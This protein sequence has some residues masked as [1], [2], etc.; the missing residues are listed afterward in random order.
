[1]GVPVMKTGSTRAEVPR[2][3][4]TRTNSEHRP[5]PF[6]RPSP[7]QVLDGCN[8]IS[9]SGLS[10]THALQG[11]GWGRGVVVVGRS[12]QPLALI[13]TFGLTFSFARPSLSRAGEERQPHTQAHTRLENP[14]TKKQSIE[15]ERTR[16]KRGR[17]H[18]Q[19]QIIKAY[20]ELLPS[21]L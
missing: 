5:P 10:S 16:E 14:Q 2:G 7:K 15:H 13:L 20:P 4:H 21:C 12:V 11:A 6:S 8:S 9:Y 18:R 3:K 19:A 1:M 17:S